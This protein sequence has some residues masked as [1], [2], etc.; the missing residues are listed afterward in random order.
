LKIKH[1]KGLSWAWWYIPVI[2]ATQKTE[3]GGLSELRCTRPAWTT[4]QDP[5]SK[6]NIH[7]LI[8]F[9]FTKNKNTACQNL[10]RGVAKVL[11]SIK[12][13]H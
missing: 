3:A 5:V 8:N 9:E 7:D 12:C 10:Y 11:L 2:Q 1:I 4:D 6:K 13:L